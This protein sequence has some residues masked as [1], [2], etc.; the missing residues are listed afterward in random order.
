MGRWKRQGVRA[1]AVVAALI[2]LSPATGLAG[3]GFPSHSGV[4]VHGGFPQGPHGQFRHVNHMG[5][6]FVH[7]PFRSHGYGYGY[8]GVVYAAPYV[9]TPYLGDYYPDPPAAYDPPAPAVQRIYVPVPTS[10]ADAYPSR[11]SVIE[12]PNGRYE[13]RGDGNW[14]PYT[15][16]WVP[17]PPPPPPDAAPAPAE[18]PASAA[19]ATRQ[20][21]RARSQLYRWVDAEGVVHLTDNPELVPE[22]ERKAARRPAAP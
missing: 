7:R 20:M 8:G 22:P 6:R 4:V 3:G 15:W 10:S 5:H 12:Y 1:G 11:P 2:A 17:N 18:P 13:L 14:T 19:P 16:V 9:G 21:A